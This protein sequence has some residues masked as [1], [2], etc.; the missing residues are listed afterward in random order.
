MPWS[1]QQ[2]DSSERPELTEWEEEWEQRVAKVR[3][4]LKVGLDS[5]EQT[6]LEC[7]ARQAGG[8]KGI[9]RREQGTGNRE[10]GEGARQERLF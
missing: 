8:K 3:V 1:A 4:A 6:F 7:L 10:E 9:G 2:V 5:F